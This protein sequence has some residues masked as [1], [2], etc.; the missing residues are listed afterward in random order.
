MNKITLDHI[1]NIFLDISTPPISNLHALNFMPQGLFSLAATV[2]VEE[3]KRVKRNGQ[4]VKTFEMFGHIPP[5]IPC[6]FHWFSTSLVN[7]IRLIGLVDL[8]NNESWKSEDI[9]NPENKQSIKSHCTNYVKKIIP[10]IYTW[11]NKVSAHFAATDPFS[12]DNLGTLEAS[13]M[14]SIVYHTPYFKAGVAQWNTKGETSQLPKWSITETYENLSDR[15]WPESKLGYEP[16]SCKAPK[17]FSFV[18]SKT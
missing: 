13:V 15:Y 12:N 11:R 2:K 16:T 9:S 14:N 17:Q 10:D 3:G 4:D 18:P 1:D 8:L 7:Y 6:T 5:I